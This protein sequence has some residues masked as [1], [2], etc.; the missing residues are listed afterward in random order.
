M[1]KLL[2]CIIL[3]SFSLNAMSQG[4]PLISDD[5]KTVQPKQVYFT[6]GFDGNLLSSSI[7]EKGNDKSKLTIPRYTAFLHLGAHMNFDFNNHVGFFVG[8]GTKNIGFIEKYPEQDS[9]VIRRAYTLGIPVGLK[10][11]NF[12]NK[13]YFFLGGGVDM[14]FHFKEKGFVKRSKKEKTTEWFSDRTQTLLPYGFI[15]AH[16]NPG[17]ALK[18]QYYPTNFLNPDFKETIEVQGQSIIHKPYENYKVNMIVLSL[19]IHINYTPKPHWD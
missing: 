16:L 17:I 6:G 19:G 2:T 1:K 11:G 14:P 15:G 13:N 5:L 7:L 9:T 18:L 10:F 8:L 4:V 3:T 12:N